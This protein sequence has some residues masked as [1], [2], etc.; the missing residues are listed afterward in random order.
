MGEGEM[1]ANVALLS[2]GSQDG[3][4]GEVE[5]DKSLEENFWEK[6]QRHRQSREPKVEDEEAEND[7]E[8]DA[9]SEEDKKS[10][11]KKRRRRKSK[12]AKVEDEGA[13]EGTEEESEESKE[14]A[15]SKRRRKSR[16]AKDQNDAQDKSEDGEKSEEE[17]AEDKIFQEKATPKKT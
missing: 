8:K 2:E 7:T 14:S 4:S 15:E 9:V 11:M 5:Q 6:K 17:S 10:F 12:H 3:A 13:L 16:E 1:E